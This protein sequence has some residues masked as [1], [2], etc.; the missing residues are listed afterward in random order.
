VKTLDQKHYYGQT[1]L[2]PYHTIL[3]AEDAVGKLG[4]AGMAGL[5]METGIFRWWT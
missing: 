3:K 1:E 4:S 5:N 2:A